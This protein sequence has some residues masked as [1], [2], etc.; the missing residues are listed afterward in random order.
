MYYIIDFV[1]TI[2]ELIKILIINRI[3]LIFCFRYEKLTNISIYCFRRRWGWVMCD[4]QYFIINLASCNYH[5][6]F[7]QFE[8]NYFRSIF[9]PWGVLCYRKLR[10]YFKMTGFWIGSA[11]DKGTSDLLIN[12]PVYQNSFW[13]MQ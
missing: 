9:A 8:V 11:F 13:L 3:F 4:I 6:L 5:L 2:D 12:K 1:L 7:R 10:R